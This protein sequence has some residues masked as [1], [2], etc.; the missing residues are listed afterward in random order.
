MVLGNANTKF[1]KLLDEIKAKR[2]CVAKSRMTSGNC[3]RITITRN[4]KQIRFYFHDNFKNQSDISD[5][6]Q[7]IVLDN[8]FYEEVRG[9]ECFTKDYEYDGKN[10]AKEL[11]YACKH[12]SEKLHKL[13]TN[14]E[15]D[16]MRENI[17]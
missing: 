16:L 8:D 10:H 4:K 12:N 6:L 1:L 15:I 2:T 17:Q 9:C 11:Y 13:F 14:D 7:A 5:W 3:Y